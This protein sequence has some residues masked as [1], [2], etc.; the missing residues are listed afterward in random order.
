MKHLDTNRLIAYFL[1]KLN[2]DEET[3]VQEH[4]HACPEC[5]KNL[6]ALRSLHKGIFEDETSVQIPL[7]KRILHSGWTKA[8]ASVI[9][10]FG[11]GFLIY[12]SISTKE[13]PINK[14]LINGGRQE[15]SIFAIDTFDKDDSLYYIEKYGDDMIRQK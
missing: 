3:A 7:F 11:A 12:H 6:E 5:R 14:D 9:I 4:L 1:N 13:S 15:N 10:I 2:Q 8:A